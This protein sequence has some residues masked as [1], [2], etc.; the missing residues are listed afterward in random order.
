[1]N[2]RGKARRTAALSIAGGVLGGAVI[3][4][5]GVGVGMY[6]TEVNGKLPPASS[7]AAPAGLMPQATTT[8][9]APPLPRATPT[10]TKI[11]PRATKTIKLPGATKTRYLPGAT[12]TIIKKVP[13]ATEK[14]APRKIQEDDPGWDCRTMGN[15]ICGPKGSAF[16][17]G[18]YR[19]R[20]LVIAWTNYSDP[21]KD[22]LWGQVKSPC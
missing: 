19:N 20:V 10:I 18:C 3:F 15:R 5:T 7:A 13:K 11:L 21:T 12:K 2:H 17:A 9:T 16:E 14:V 6:P 22:P 4:M 8:I 1:M